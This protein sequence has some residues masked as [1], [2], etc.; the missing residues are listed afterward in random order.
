M[1]VSSNLIIFFSMFSLNIDADF[2]IFAAF[3]F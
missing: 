2:V 1:L 3:D